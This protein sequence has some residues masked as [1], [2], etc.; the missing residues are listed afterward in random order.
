MSIETETNQETPVQE[1]ETVEVAPQ[2]ATPVAEVQ[3]DVADEAAFAAGFTGEEPEAAQPEPPKEEEPPE[4]QTVSLTAEELADLKA[5]AAEI[6]KLKEREQRIY[7]TLGSLKQSID[8]LRNQ[9]RPSATAVQ[10]TKEKFAKLSTMFPE[11]AELLAE[12]LN[13]VLTGAGSQPV[14]TAQ[15]EQTFDTKLNEKLQQQQQQFE[16]KVLS[17]MHPDWKPVVPSDEFQKWKQS[18]PQETQAE[19][20]T[21]W[22]AEFIGSKLSE[23]KDWKSKAV[24][25]QAQKRSRLEAA[26]TPKGGAQAPVKTLDD[27]FLQGFKEA[28][29]IA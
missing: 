7:G 17:V 14:D 16:A 24:Q 15:F 1:A 28:K 2:D 20:D 18:L 9:P 3:Q 21:S 25:G 6:D 5:K 4:P 27:A 22:D 8:Q 23:F 10:L 11:M 12:D 13:G 19:L 29:G 26:I